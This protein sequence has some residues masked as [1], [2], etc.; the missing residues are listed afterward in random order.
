MRPDGPVYWLDHDDTYAIISIWYY[1]IHCNLNLKPSCQMLFIVCSTVCIYVHSWLLWLHSPS[2]LNS[3]L[4]DD[5]NG[6]LLACYTVHSYVRSQGLDIPI[7]LWVNYGDT[8][9]LLLIALSS[10]CTCWLPS[11]YS[12]TPPNSLDGT[13]PVLPAL[14]LQYHCYK[15]RHSQPDLAIRLDVGSCMLTLET[16]SIAGTRHREVWG[17]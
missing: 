4:P 7:Y 12:I 17:W 5:L 13:L 2:L 1:T 6:T 10:M 16:S 15:M 11:M 14:R 8:S 9:E 3:P